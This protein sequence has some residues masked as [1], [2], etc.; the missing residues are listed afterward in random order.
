[1]VASGLV[2]VSGW[3]VHAYQADEEAAS[4]IAADAYAI[5]NRS[6]FE[7]HGLARQEGGLRLDSNEAINLGGDSGSPFDIRD[8]DAGELMRRIR[9]P[10]GH[11]EVMPNN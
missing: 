1:M 8:P 11:A 6:C 4:S 3:I 5:L 9:L 2:C 7:C 10:K